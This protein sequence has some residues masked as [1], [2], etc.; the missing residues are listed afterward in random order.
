MSGSEVLDHPDAGETSFQSREGVPSYVGETD[1]KGDWLGG[2]NPV[3]RRENGWK[4]G[5]NKFAH[6]EQ[7]TKA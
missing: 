1:I 5:G 2:E 7:L 3:Q 6:S 4:H